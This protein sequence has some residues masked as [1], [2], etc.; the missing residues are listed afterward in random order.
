T[1]DGGKAWE[2]IEAPTNYSLMSVLWLDR[3]RALVATGDYS[4]ERAHDGDLLL[5]EDG[6]KTWRV[7]FHISSPCRAMALNTT[8]TGWG[9]GPRG[10]K[11]NKITYQGREIHGV[12]DLTPLERKTMP[13]DFKRLL[14]L[15]AEWN[16]TAL[17]LPSDPK[18][19]LSKDVVTAD[20]IQIGGTG[21]L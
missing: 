21:S 15:P 3:Q 4:R 10:A 18:Q 11:P 20:A 19:P 13:A 7:F 1:A 2:R 5:T 16:A 12:S 9:S 14:T 8:R 6:G 17:A